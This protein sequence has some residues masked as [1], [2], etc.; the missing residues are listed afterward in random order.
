MS[1]YITPNHPASSPPA[2]KME[3]IK[4]SPK[5][6]ILPSES[7]MEII[8]SPPVRQ[9]AADSYEIPTTTLN[10][11]KVGSGS[12][13]KVKGNIHRVCLNRWSCV[14]SLD[15]NLKFW[16]IFLYFIKCSPKDYKA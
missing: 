3:I 15:Y 7:K 11:K 1:D 16:L 12:D 8:K 6:E 13:T 10:Y 5:S 14:N 9:E 4:A 2:N